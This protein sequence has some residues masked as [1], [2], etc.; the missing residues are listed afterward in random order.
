M[1]LTALTFCGALLIPS[2]Y[3]LKGSTG[4]IV[5]IAA[6][7]A[8]VFLYQ[9]PTL[10]SAT[11]DIRLRMGSDQMTTF[12]G[13][14][15]SFTYLLEHLFNPAWWIPKGT[16]VFLDEYGSFPHS[17][18]TAIYLQAGLLGLVGWTMLVMVPLLKGM[19]HVWSREG[20]TFTAMIIGGG[21]ISWLGAMTLPASFFGQAWLWA[22]ATAGAIAVSLRGRPQLPAQ[23]KSYLKSWND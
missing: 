19:R 10:I 8:A 3:R 2:W 7:L 20:D 11:T 13:R 15:R 21:F 22:G 4:R 6:L 9:L 14:V 17:A 23:L 12:F 18:P 16:G 1:I 5:L